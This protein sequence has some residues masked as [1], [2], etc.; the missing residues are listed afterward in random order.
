MW[1]QHPFVVK[2][3]IY[4]QDPERAWISFNA[5]VPT[6]SGKFDP[7]A[8]MKVGPSFKLYLK[9]QRV[10]I[11]YWKARAGAIPA[12]S[13]V[14]GAAF[15]FPG[16]KIL[17][18][19][20]EAELRIDRVVKRSSTDGYGGVSLDGAVRIVF[21]TA[22]LNGIF[23]AHDTLRPDEVVRDAQAPH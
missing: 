20:W 5:Q 21:S 8:R 3:A 7:R 6:T 4:W 23:S 1:S 10:A 14:E 15:Q 18:D 9:P 22:T 13:L 19:N 16:G 2:T 11:G 12:D 17:Q